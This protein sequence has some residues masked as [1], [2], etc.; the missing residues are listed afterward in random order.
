[1]G[2]YND[3]SGIVRRY[4]SEAQAWESHL[5]AWSPSAGT[6]M[7]I[8]LNILTQLAALPAYGG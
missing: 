5:E 8:S 6:E 4:A 2:F 1:M 7:V 3:Q